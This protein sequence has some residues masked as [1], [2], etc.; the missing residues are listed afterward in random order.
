MGP[1]VAE[2]EAEKSLNLQLLN[3]LVIGSIPI[4]WTSRAGALTERDRVD[5]AMSLGALRP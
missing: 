1:L 2:M 3:S 5:P 4:W